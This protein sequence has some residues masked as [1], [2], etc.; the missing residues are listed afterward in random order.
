MARLVRRPRGAGPFAAARLPAHGSR[1]PG[2]PGGGNPAA[3][4]GDPGARLA[5][6]AGGGRGAGGRRAPDPGGAEPGDQRGALLAAGA[7]R[8]WWARRSGTGRRRCGWR[9]PGLGV[10]PRDRERIFQRHVQGPT[11]R[12]GSGLGLAIARAIAEAHGG[13]LELAR[14]REGT[15]ARFVMPAPRGDRRGDGGGAMSRLL[16]VEDEE[17]IARFVERGLRAAGH[18]V[19]AVGDGS[20]ALMAVRNGA[21]DLVVLDLGL[22]DIDGLEVL[23]DASARRAT[24]CRWCCSPPATRWPTKVLGFEGGADDY[25]TKPFAFEELLVRVRARLRVVGRAEAQEL[26]HGDLRPRP[27][28]PAGDDAGPWAK[29][30]AVEPR[31]RPARDPTRHPGATPARARSCSTACGASTSTP[32]RTSSRST[33]ATCAARSAPTASGP[34]AAPVTGWPEDLTRPGDGPPRRGAVASR[35][36]RGAGRGPAAAVR[37]D[38]DLRPVTIR[39]DDPDAAR[40]GRRRHRH[41]RP[42]GADGVG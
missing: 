13:R 6:R 12:S 30:R 40:A 1:G 32:A 33:S 38:F 27:A 4:G 35:R 25:L 37:V 18:S 26:V 22:P 10:S 17:R 31:V 24:G 36:W 14:P 39:T 16:V 34:S 3:G 21:P 7:R 29:H 23:A 5:G 42:A 20:S 11:R 2:R 19:E 28:R 8:W 9:T 41:D 15:G